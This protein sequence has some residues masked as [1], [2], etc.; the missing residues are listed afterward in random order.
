MRV[1][2]DTPVWSTLLRRPKGRLSQDDE[3]T[4][5]AARELISDGRAVLLAPVRQEVLQGIR[6][7]AVFRQVRDHLEDLGDEPLWASDYS[8]A[9]EL[10]NLCAA[11]GV[12][13]TS[14]DL[15]ICA[16]ALRLRAAVFTLDRDFAAYSRVTGVRLFTPVTH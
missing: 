9:A 2:I 12:Q 5:A 3:E 7:A 8:R 4:I 16:A 6:S 13:P 14:I 1:V 11:R 10:F 15:L